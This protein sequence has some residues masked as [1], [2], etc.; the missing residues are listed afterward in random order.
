MHRKI[1]AFQRLH[2]G[3][4]DADAA[5]PQKGRSLAADHPICGSGRGER[6]A[7]ASSFVFTAC[8]FSC[9]INT[10]LVSVFAGG[11]VPL[12]SHS[13]RLIVL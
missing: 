12:R 3:E 2:P 5:Q 6:C 1:D 9:V 4:F 11:L 8:Q 7:H 10:P 13:T